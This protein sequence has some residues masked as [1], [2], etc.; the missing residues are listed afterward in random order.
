MD[1]YLILKL[2]VSLLITYLVGSTFIPIDHNTILAI[3]SPLATI[4][5]MLFGFIIASIIFLSSSAGNELIQGLK[6]TH[7]YRSLMSKLHFTGVGLITSCIFMVLSIFSPFKKIN[8]NY[9]YTWDF[10]LLIIGFFALIY[11]LI[12]FWFCWKKLSLVIKN[13]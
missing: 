8:L 9:E 4:A 5:S 2:S 10:S 1:F 7:M 11:S 3:S 12:E 13:M 6:D